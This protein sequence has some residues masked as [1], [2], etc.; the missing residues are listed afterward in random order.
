VPIRNFTTGRWAVGD[1]A[2]PHKVSVGDDAM[3]F[4]RTRTER[5]PSTPI[6]CCFSCY[7]A[8]RHGTH[9]PLSCA[10]RNG[11]DGETLYQRSHAAV[12]R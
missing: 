9:D 11:W 4:R 2:R 12:G 6:I 3:G 5:A 8:Y 10:R 7:R 1:E